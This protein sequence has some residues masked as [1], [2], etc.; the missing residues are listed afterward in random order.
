L[1]YAPSTTLVTLRGEI[2]SNYRVYL[3]WADG[4]TTVKW[5]D[6][7]NEAHACFLVGLQAGKAGMPE[8]IV[9]KIS[10]V[11]ETN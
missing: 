3:T 10:A 4:D 2:V 7:N 9:V 8:G 5:V 6:A 1:S 11:V